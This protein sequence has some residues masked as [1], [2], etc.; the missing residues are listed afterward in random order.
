M[1]NPTVPP[2]YNMIY[3]DKKDGTL[4]SEAYL[5]NEQLFQVLNNMITPNGIK[6]P[7]FTTAQVTAFPSTVFPGTTWYNSDLKKLQFKDDTGIIKT[8]TSTP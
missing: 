6:F 7:S 2:F 4:S 8:I 1:A 5:Y 3:I